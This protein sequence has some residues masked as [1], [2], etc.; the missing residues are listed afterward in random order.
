M[1]TIFDKDSHVDQLFFQK[2]KQ[3]VKVLSNVSYIL[4]KIERDGFLKLIRESFTTILNNEIAFA[5]SE[6]SKIEKGSKSF[7]MRNQLTNNTYIFKENLKIVTNFIGF[8]ISRPS[9]EGQNEKREYQRNDSI[10]DFV[11]EKN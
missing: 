10:R 5:V 11:V 7:D 6:L 3:E 9:L 1:N 2:I 4:E 8:L